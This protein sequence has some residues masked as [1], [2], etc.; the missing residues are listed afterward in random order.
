MRHTHGPTSPKGGGSGG[1]RN[2][3]FSSVVLGWIGT[4]RTRLLITNQSEL[5]VPRDEVARGRGYFSTRNSRV[6]HGCD[7]VLPHFVF[8][9]FWGVPITEDEQYRALTS[10]DSAFPNENMKRGF[11]LGSLF[12]IEDT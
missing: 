8:L 5:K 2:G 12:L 3:L 1:S 4:S 9:S 7:F 11:L 6:Y 10:P